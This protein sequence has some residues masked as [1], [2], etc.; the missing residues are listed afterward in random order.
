MTSAAFFP[1]ETAAHLCWHFGPQRCIIVRDLIPTDAVHS[2]TGVVKTFRYATQS[3]SNGDR[4]IVW[5]PPLFTN[6]GGAD[7]VVG[8]TLESAWYLQSQS[9]SPIRITSDTIHPSIVP[10]VQPSYGG[11]Y[12]TARNL[13][14]DRVVAAGLAPEIAASFPFDF[15][16][17][18]AFRMSAFWMLH[19]AAWIPHLPYD[20]SHGRDLLRLSLDPERS[21]SDRHE[22]ARHLHKWET[23]NS[24][25][26]IRPSS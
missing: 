25:S 20:E 7:I 9:Q 21:Q 2:R 6:A 23:D 17:R 19:A 22:F 4:N 12:D 18:T 3:M 13:V 10:L 11:D 16:V 8:V 26:L 5:L 15:P 14:T 1:L 24:I